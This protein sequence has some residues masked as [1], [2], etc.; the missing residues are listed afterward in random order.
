[1]SCADVCIDMDVDVSNEFYR[2]TRHK[3]KLHHVCCECHKGIMPGES[4]WYAVGKD[5][6]D[7]KPWTAKTCDDCY[8]VRRALVCGSW[9]FGRL[10]EEIDGVVFPSWE[11]HGPFDC[12]AQVEPLTARNKL[13]TQYEQYKE[14]R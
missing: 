9:E 4:Y 12:L 3:A 2:E 10:W 13:R 8:N 7:A 6:H 1:M 14:S 11:T 5:R